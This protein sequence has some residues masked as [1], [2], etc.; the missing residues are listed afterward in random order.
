MSNSYAGYLLKFGNTVM[1]NRYFLEYSSTPDRISDDDAGTDQ[2]GYL[3][4]SPLPHKRSTVKFSTHQMEL[5]DKITFQAIYQNAIT[6]SAERKATV[7][8]WN[9]DT[10]AYQTSDFYLPDI[11]FS[12]RDADSHTIY[13]N[14][15]TVEL[16]EY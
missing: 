16:V 1:P 7:T 12:V 8:F 6:N 5:D 9:D 14:P 13:Y 11:E 15:I 10:N 2:N 4:R 3:W